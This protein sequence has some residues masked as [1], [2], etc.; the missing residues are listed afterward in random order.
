M[1]VEQSQELMIGCCSPREQYAV[2]E[3]STR[4]H[5]PEISNTRPVRGQKTTDVDL[6]RHAN[7]GWLQV[8]MVFHCVYKNVN[9]SASIM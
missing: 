5:S 6:C 2:Y 7:A 3:I 8:Y 4:G 1:S 9:V